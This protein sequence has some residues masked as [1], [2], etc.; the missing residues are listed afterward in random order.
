MCL[1]IWGDLYT[2]PFHYFVQEAV[3]DKRLLL[4]YGYLGRSCM[5][6]FLVMGMS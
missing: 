1:K 3:P 5:P 4:T 6:V 2:P